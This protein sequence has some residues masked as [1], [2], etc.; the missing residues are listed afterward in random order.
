[1]DTFTEELRQA[2]PEEERGFSESAVRIAL[3]EGMSKSAMKRI[4]MKGGTYKCMKCSRHTKDLSTLLKHIKKAKHYYGVKT[5]RDE[6]KEF[7]DEFNN[8]RGGAVHI[9][10]FTAVHAEYEK[11]E[12]HE[13]DWYAELCFL[14]ICQVCFQRKK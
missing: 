5:L 12:P 14:Q 13:K 6:K 8:E 7:V 4:L 9:T 2:L 10:D 1:M 11:M 3:D